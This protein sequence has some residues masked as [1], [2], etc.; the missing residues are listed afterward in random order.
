MTLLH[1]LVLAVVQGITEF[2]P[3][4]SSAHLVLLHEMGG[5]RADAIALDVAV[6]LGSI[7]AV[8]IYFWADVRA[9]LTGLCHLARGSRDGFEARLALGLIIATIPAVLVGAV[10]ALT[11]WVDLLRN[12]TVI[13]WTMIVFGALL[14]AAHRFCPERRKVEDW[15]WRDAVIMGLWQ[16]LALIPGV[17]RS[18]ITMTAARLIGFKRHEAARIAVLMSVPITLASGGYLMLQVGRSPVSDALLYNA[19]LAAVLAF[20]AAY[21]ALAAMMR[22]LDRVSFTPYVI[23]RMLLGA[24]LLALAYG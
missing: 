22:L 3:I 10:L 4:S 8:V 1:L 17:S 6:H 12:A 19:A 15:R 23:Y 21:L 13:G 5:P 2:L 20:V 18:G 14:W 7:G 11:G 24:V 16:A 9:A